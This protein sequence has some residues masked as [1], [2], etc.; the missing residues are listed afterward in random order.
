MT[1]PIYCVALVFNLVGGYTADKTGWKALHVSGSCALSVV[2]FIICVVVA[3][4]AARYVTAILP[5][6]DPKIHFYMFRWRWDLDGYSY[7]SQ[8]DGNDV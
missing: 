5:S 4:N 2:S 8:L 6:A 1:V 7:L 3:N